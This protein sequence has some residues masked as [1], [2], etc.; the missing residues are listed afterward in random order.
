LKKRRRRRRQ[1]LVELVLPSPT[2]QPTLVG[3]QSEVAR[4]MS[5]ITAEYEAA[6]W[7]LSGQ[8]VG[9]SQHQFI[10]ARLERMEDARQELEQLVGPEEST[11]L[12]VERLEKGSQSE[13]G[14]GP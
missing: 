5:Q 11:R 6:Q 9:V 1:P 7:A 2:A 12:F 4:L 14:E 13:E 3:G 10:T 8:A